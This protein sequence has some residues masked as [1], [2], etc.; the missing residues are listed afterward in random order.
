M[1]QIGRYNAELGKVE[2]FNPDEDKPKAKGRV[3]FGANGWATGLESDGAGCHSSQ[4]DEFN[5]MAKDHG[6]TGVHYDKSGQCHFS[7]RGQR[8]KWLEIR[9]I[10]DN[11][12]GYGD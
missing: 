7:S 4:V 1:R 10:R 11:D 9:G 3:H 2:W 6:L 12:G 5:A 8:K